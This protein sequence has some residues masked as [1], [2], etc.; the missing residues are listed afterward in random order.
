MYLIQAKLRKA[1]T[2]DLPHHQ[3]QFKAKQRELRRAAGMCNAEVLMKFVQQTVSGYGSFGFGWKINVHFCPQSTEE[4]SQECS[5]IEFKE[6]LNQL[7]S[8]MSMMSLDDLYRTE[9]VCNKGLNL[10]QYDMSDI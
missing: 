10:F 9:M 6:K 5:I 7:I 3:C 1:H 8:G 4:G 2:G